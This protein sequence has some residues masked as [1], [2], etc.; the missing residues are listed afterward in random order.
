MKCDFIKKQTIKDK[1]YH[2]KTLM[3]DIKIDYPHLSSE[4]G[5]NMRFNMHFRQKAHSNYRYAYTKLYQA[6][7]K[8]YATS[9]SQGFPFHAFEFVE[10]FE[11]TYCKKPFI[12]L[13]YDIYEFTGGAHGNTTRKGSTW[14]MKKNTMI[15]LDSLFVK[16]WDYK[17][18]IL[19]YVEA[20]AKR[21]MIMGKGNF[22]DD[23]EKNLAKYFDEKNFYLTE[24][25]LAI[26]YPLYT[27]APYSDGI[28]VFIIPYPLFGEHLKYKL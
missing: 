23:L 14:D 28:H 27:I 15:T 16:N 18:F 24:E 26:F 11:P 12:S 25:G 19:R 3:V 21:K 5:N 7:V 22:F 8:H 9:K 10:V 17:L 2:N 1:L 13:Y 6:A 20:D 4:Y